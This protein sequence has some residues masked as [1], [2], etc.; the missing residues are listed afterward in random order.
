MSSYKLQFIRRPLVQVK[1]S[2]FSVRLYHTPNAL[3]SAAERAHG[4]HVT[5]NNILAANLVPR[6][7]LNTLGKQTGQGTMFDGDGKIFWIHTPL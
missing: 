3:M 1:I 5:R 7:V 2:G 4:I 6:Q